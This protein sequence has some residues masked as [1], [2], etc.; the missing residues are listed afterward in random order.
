MTIGTFD[1]ELEAALRYDDQAGRLGKPVN[2]PEEGTLQK[3]AM[4]W[5]SASAAALAS[6]R[7]PTLKDGEIIAQI[8]KKSR[9]TTKKYASCLS[10]SLLSSPASSALESTSELSVEDACS[11]SIL[12]A[13]QEDSNKFLSSQK[14]L[15][16]VNF[17][18]TRSV[19]SQWRA[20]IRVNGVRRVLGSF[21]SAKEAARAY[22]DEAVRHGMETNYKAKLPSNTSSLVEKDDDSSKMDSISTS[23][24]SQ[25]SEGHT[26]SE[27]KQKEFPPTVSSISALNTKPSVV[28]S[29]EKEEGTGCHRRVLRH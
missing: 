21:A 6:P 4:K 9:R 12:T 16:G 14:K 8:K 29:A 19:G 28:S 2:F 18:K 13:K 25:S 15:M 27:S 22:D 5:G 10:S 1:D 26:F 7:S 17:D 3:K 24:I 11:S 23:A 20:R